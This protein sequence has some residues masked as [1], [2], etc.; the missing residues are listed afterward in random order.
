MARLGEARLHATLQSCGDA[1]I[2]TDEAG[3]VTMV[4]PV[5]ETLTGWTHSEAE[6]LRLEQ[7][8]PIVSELTRETLESPVSR[9]LREGKVVAL[10][11]HTLLLARDGTE[12][13][14]DDSAAPIRGAN[15]DIVG[16][17]AGVSRRYGAQAG[18]P[19]ARASAAGGGGTRS[20]GQSQRGQRSVPRAG[21]PRAALTA[22]GDPRVAASAGQRLRSPVR[23]TRRA[24]AD[25]QKHPAP[26]AIGERSARHLAHIG[27]EAGSHSQPGRPGE[28]RAGS[29][30]RLQLDGRAAGR[31]ARARAARAASVRARR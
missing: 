10:P 1:L 3:K 23:S 15:G 12:R 31:H 4:N 20:G 14:I 25:L 30:R 26:G 11:D 28:D 27:R 13:P 21:L 9:V 7:V 6:G 18:R 16:D 24:A 29:D 2:V 8:F 19:G 22:R 17:R 5:A